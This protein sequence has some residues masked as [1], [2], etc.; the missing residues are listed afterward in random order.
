MPNGVLIYDT[1]ND[2]VT[3]KNDLLSDILGANGDG[4]DVQI[5]QLRKD[6]PKDDEGQIEQQNKS[7]KDVLH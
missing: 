4:F 7:F 6:E 2:E 3:F 5:K 1:L